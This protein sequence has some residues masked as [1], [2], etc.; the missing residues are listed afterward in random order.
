AEAGTLSEAGSGAVAATATGAACCG[1][2]GTGFAAAIAVGE[3]SDGGAEATFSPRARRRDQSATSRASSGPRIVS[4]DGLRFQA[5]W[6]RANCRSCSALYFAYCRA[7]AC[8]ISEGGQACIGEKE[9]PGAAIWLNWYCLSQTST[10]G[11]CLVI[12]KWS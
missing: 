10:L 7:R 3:G 4:R 9:W 6:A 2:A 5:V 11:G 12:S 1:A 8:G